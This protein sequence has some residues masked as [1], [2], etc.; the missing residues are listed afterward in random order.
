MIQVNCDYNIKDD[1]EFFL[2]AKGINNLELS[3]NIHVSRSTLDE[4]L[5]KGHAR[6]EVYEKFYSYAY[7][8]NYRLNSVKEELLKEKFKNILFHG[9]KNG[10]SFVDDNGSRDK[11][12]FG[13]GFYLGETYNPDDIESLTSSEGYGSLR[14]VAHEA[15]AKMQEAA[16]LDGV[17][18]YATS[19]YR[20]YDTQVKIYNSYLVND[21]QEVVD[22]YSARPGFSDHQT[23]LTVDILSGGYDFGNFY[24][25]TASD[26]LA[27][28]AYKY[29]FIC[30][31]PDG[32]TDATG[33][34]YEPWH[35]RYV[36]DI[37]QDVYEKGISYDEYF[38]KYIKER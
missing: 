22:T 8:E 36:G 33:Y 37:A 32:L 21:P 10:L 38:E 27:K 12:D 11:C 26:W 20:S 5:K 31:Y 13:G 34:T 6:K 4:V 17:D 30:R 7:K 19:S 1:I 23:G 28:N 9:S 14:K 29:G 15:Y 3:E 35:Y 25:S 24:A 16:S 2:E 18:F